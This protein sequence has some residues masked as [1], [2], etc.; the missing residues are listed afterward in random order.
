M[1]VVLKCFFLAIFISSGAVAAGD[2]S[3][4]IPH[5]TDAKDVLL[6]MTQAMKTLNYQGTVAFLKNGRLEP[7]KYFHAV[8]KGV[9]QER[10]LSLNSP[11]REIIRDSDRVSCLFKARHQLIVD[12]RPFERSFLIDIPANLDALDAIY[13]IT[14]VGEAYVAMLPVLVIAIQPKDN[15]RYARKIWVDKQHF[16]P[17]KVLVYD[18]ANEAI[19]QLVFTEFQLKDTLPLVDA[20]LLNAVNPPP[21]VH[22]LPIQKSDQANFVL[23]N[24]P[25]GF[26]ELFFTRKPMHNSDQQVDHL[27]M[28]DGFASVSIYMENKNA[29]TQPE[30]YAQG[31]VQSVGTVN[32]I[33]RTLGDFEFTVMGEVPAETVKLIADGIKLRDLKN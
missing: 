16:L 8:E 30:L 19:E 31:G 13:N 3:L 32:F 6:K 28:S 10:L 21:S 1:T 26:H 25:Q 5:N 2:S 23:T 7:M 12:Q 14:V 18:L 17:L 33:S 9:E 11:L 27:L 20:K 15:F 4:T 22:P 24:L 29:A